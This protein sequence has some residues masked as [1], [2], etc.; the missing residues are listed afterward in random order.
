[1]KYFVI[2]EEIEDG[3]YN[4]HCYSPLN[5]QTRLQKYFCNYVNEN[6]RPGY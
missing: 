1:M 3:G 5:N 6:N 2:I 4:A